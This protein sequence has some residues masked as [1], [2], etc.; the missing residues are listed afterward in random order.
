VV[1]V[2]DVPARRRKVVDPIAVTDD[3]GCMTDIRAPT[4]PPLDEASP[5]LPPAWRTAVEELVTH[6]RLERGR[7]P[8][9]VDAYRRDAIDLA[10]RA[11][12]WG[13]ERPG[14]LTRDDLRRYLAEL[15]EEG[16]ARSTLARRTS[17][18]RTWFA[19]LE[20]R[21]MITED[22]AALLATPKQG[23][24]LPRVLRVD[25]V[26]AMLDT[27][28]GDGPSQLRDRALLEL[29]YASGARV[30]EACGLTSEALDLAQA[31]VRLDGKGG[32][33]RI[34]PIGRAAVRA[35]TTYLHDARPALLRV[36]AARA[37]AGT[38]PPT[39]AIVLRGDRG[40]PLGTRD[41]RAIVERAGLRAGVG[42]VTPHTLRHSFA[43]HLLEGGADVRVVQE[44]LGHASLATTQRYTHLSRGRLR[45]VH[46][47]AH[48]RARTVR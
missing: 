10:R 1:S 2:C 8:H 43:T 13:L 20:R 38:R 6:R 4:D 16:F 41:A 21:G 23:R 30:A 37:T 11:S 32:K 3:A 25:Q 17:T 40:G 39:D 7:R 31:Q 18:L 14:D 29:L 42:H 46:A 24:H 47:M 48:P 44:L 45:E 27:L 15:D 35:L 26:V 9:T 19:L 12:A 33:D 28:E 34:V 22:P 5:A 36:D